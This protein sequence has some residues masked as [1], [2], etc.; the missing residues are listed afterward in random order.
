MSSN[1]MRKGGVLDNTGRNFTVE[2]YQTNALSIHF[3]INKFL[4]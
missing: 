1:V 3:R 4:F 2:D